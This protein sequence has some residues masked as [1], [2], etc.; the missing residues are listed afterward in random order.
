MEGEG[1][2]L[3]HEQMVHGDVGSL[4]AA[5]AHAAVPHCASLAHTPRLL[6][7]EGGDLGGEGREGR[8]GERGR[9][10]GSEGGSEGVMKATCRCWSP[11]EKTWGKGER[12]REGGKD[13]GKKGEKRGAEKLYSTSAQ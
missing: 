13:G 2:S 3:P 11:R 7:V 9:E 4:V 8:E 1:P 12:R 10:G 5:A 6:L